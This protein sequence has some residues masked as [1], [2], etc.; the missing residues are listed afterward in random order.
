M[1]EQS[2]VNRLH[3]HINDI[4][5]TVQGINVDSERGREERQKALIQITQARKYMD[6]IGLAHGLIVGP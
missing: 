3:E 1:P 2:Q 6:S 4:W 5:M